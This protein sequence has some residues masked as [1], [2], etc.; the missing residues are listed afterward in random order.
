MSLV[1]ELKQ[2]LDA[3]QQLYQQQMQR[4]TDQLRQVSSENQDL[5]N[6]L[7]ML[8]LNEK[9]SEKEEK[10]SEENEKDSEKS[11]SESDSEVVVKD[12]QREH[13]HHSGFSGIKINLSK[14][15]VLMVRT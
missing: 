9:E 1:E 7:T 2:Q 8:Q 12:K 6:K 10:E 4:L 13:H 14:F 5:A 3:M 11:D 15:G